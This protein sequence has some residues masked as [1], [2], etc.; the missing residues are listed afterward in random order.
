MCVCELPLNRI[1]ELLQ[2]ICVNYFIWQIKKSLLDYQFNQM[3]KQSQK[4]MPKCSSSIILT[5]NLVI[6]HELKIETNQHRH[7]W[8]KN[9][10][11]LSH[12]ILADYLL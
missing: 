9:T 3:S 6:N 2:Y 11:I 5:H 1:Q 10:I 7:R 12:D 4:I 8:A